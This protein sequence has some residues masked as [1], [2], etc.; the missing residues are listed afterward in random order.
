MGGGCAY[1]SHCITLCSTCQGLETGEGLSGTPPRVG[2]LKVA[3][4][5]GHIDKL[6][7]SEKRS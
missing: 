6:G 2:K 7:W 3:Y 1:M 5:I 4:I